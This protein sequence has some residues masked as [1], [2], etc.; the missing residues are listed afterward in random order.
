MGT[1]EGKV[2]ERDLDLDSR[3]RS[4]RCVNAISILEC[5]LSADFL[6]RQWPFW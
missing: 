3:V 1:P 4:F 2:C 6:D 5:G